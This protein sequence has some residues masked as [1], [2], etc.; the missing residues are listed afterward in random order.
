MPNVA[1]DIAVLTGDLIRS[2][3]LRAADLRRAI[4]A[5][6]QA[7][8][9]I[10]KWDGVETAFGLRGG[11]GWQLVLRPAQLALRAALT[12]RA[13]LRA[14]GKS[15]DSRIAIADGG[16]AMP[17][18]GNPN[19]ALGPVYVTSG[20]ALEAMKGEDGLRWGTD[21]KGAATLLADHI[22]RDWTPAQARALKPQLAPQPPRREDTART[23]NISR[24]SVNK[25]LWAA[26]YPALSEALQMIET[27][28]DR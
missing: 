4:A 25:A 3:D 19:A 12:L 28:P 2:T 17:P 24:Q 26:G 16:D 22:S 10:A 18:D 6:Q 21:A 27:A 9:D 7:A 14:L 5:L 8:E 15:Y 1:P 23:L 11:D 13:A 20:R